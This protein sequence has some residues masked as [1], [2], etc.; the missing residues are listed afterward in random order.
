MA[1]LLQQDDQPAP[2]PS[3]PSAAP[4]PGGQPQPD[5]GQPSNQAPRNGQP[6]GDAPVDPDTV[7]KFIA[8][9]MNVVT[10]SLKSLIQMVQQA[11]DKS[12]ALAQATVQ[13]VLRVEDSF[14]EAGGTLSLQMTLQGGAETL[15]DIADAVQQAG[16]YDYSDQEIETAFLRAVDQYRMIRAQQGRIDQ[17]AAQQKM[18]QLKAAEQNGTLE[19]EYPGLAEFAQKSAKLENEVKAETGQEPEGDEPAS[20]NA[21]AGENDFPPELLAKREAKTNPKSKGRR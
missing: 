1:G 17:G 16:V 11:S 12:A 8:N 5:G 4:A 18:Q 15:T 10:A 7:K 2:V 13:T 21:P 3:G 9:C 20:G 19:K 6:I 14:E